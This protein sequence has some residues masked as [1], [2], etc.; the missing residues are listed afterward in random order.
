[1][2][3]RTAYHALRSVARV[4]PGEWAVVLGAAGGVGLAAV[5]LGAVLGARVVAAASSADKLAAV[6]RAR[7][8]G[9]RSTTATEDLKERIKEITGGGAD[10][11]VDPVG[12]PDAERPSGP[13]G[14]AA[15]S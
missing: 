12:G 4:Q 1:M 15:A 3:H 14:G 5:E 9:R 13:C 2:A 8:R 7:S 11:V 10:V 6:P